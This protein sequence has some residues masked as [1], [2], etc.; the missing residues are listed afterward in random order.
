MD[1]SDLFAVK[2]PETDEVGYSCV[3]GGLEEVFALAVFLG[4]EVLEWK[5]GNSGQNI[6]YEGV[7]KMEWKTRLTELLGCRYPIMQGGLSALGTWE[8][9]QPYLRLVPTVA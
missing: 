6:S 8:F 3:M 5:M 2:N 1:D 9:L 4:P 7:N